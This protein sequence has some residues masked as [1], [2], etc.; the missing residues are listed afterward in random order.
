LRTER[1]SRLTLR[2]SGLA[3]AWHLAR[4]AL[5]VIIR[6]AGQAPSR[7]SPLSSNVRAHMPRRL[8]IFDLDETLVHAT[9]EHLGRAA[10]FSFPPYNVYVRPHAQELLAFVRQHFDIAVWSSAQPEYVGHVAGKLFGNHTPLRFVWSVERCVQRPDP[11]TNSYVYIKDLRKVQSQGYPVELVT[12]VD[13]SPEKVRRQPRNHVR[14][15]PFHG[16]S[17]DAELLSV[18]AMLAELVSS[19]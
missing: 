7:R 12:L 2:S 11:Q 14:V 10:D 17:T 5:Q 1:K 16:E 4:E 3:P 13:D 19:P 18:Q 9:E 8:V 15:K 6:L